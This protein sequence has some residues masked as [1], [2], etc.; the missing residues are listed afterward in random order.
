M[1]TALNPGTLA[2]GKIINVPYSGAVKSLNLPA[3]KYKLE[4][5][6]AEGGTAGSHIGGKGGYSVGELTLRTGKM[7]F[8]RVGGRGID[9]PN[10]TSKDIIPGGFNGGGSGVSWTGTTHYGASGGGGTDICIGEESHYARVIVAGGGGGGSDSANG[11]AGGGTSGIA[12]TNAAGTATSGSG[13]GFAAKAAYTGGECGGG[14]GGW[15][16]G[17]GGS[18]ENNSG[19]G[20]SGYVFTTSTKSQYP[21]GCKLDDTMLLTNASTKAG[22]T[23]FIDPESG[24]SVTGRTGNGYIRITVLA[25]TDGAG[26]FYIANAVGS[27]TLNMPAKF[28]KGDYI[29]FNVTNI[30]EATGYKG[31]ILKITIPTACKIKIH[32]YGSRGAYGNLYTSGLTDTTRSGNG[33]YC[34]GTFSFKKGDELL[35]LVGQHGKDAMTGASSTKDQTNGGGGGAT[36][37]AKRVASGGMK[38]IGC[39]DSGSTAYNGWLVQ[40]LI[41]AAGGNGSRDNGYSGTGTIYDGLGHTT[42]AEALQGSTMQGGTFSLE[43]GSMSSN[44]SSYH[45]G[46]SFLQGG[47]GSMYSYSRTTNSLGG[48]GGGGANGDDT[49]GGGGGGWIGGAK[50]VAAKSYINTTLGANVGSAAGNNGGDGYVTFEILE[51]GSAPNVAIANGTFKAGKEAYVYV[52]DTL[53]FR[54]VKELFVMDDTG[55]WRRSK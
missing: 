42:A 37:I 12:G 11:G 17:T 35:I 43:A 2:V 16:G 54:P 5:W 47:L 46:R 41:V 4:C 44:S 8:L 34:Y 20:G 32:A 9:D 28:V 14:G 55:Q 45:Y 52:N 40:A 22:N 50:G 53:K 26:N 25:L 1:A 48:F 29:Q 6:G 21:S 30:N 13:F 49:E 3:G 7:L 27:A 38:F 31:T 10:V 15:Y 23:S 24:S 36:I 39:A 19:G 33:A 51:T 18:A